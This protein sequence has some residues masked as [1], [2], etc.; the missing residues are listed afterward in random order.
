MPAP[1]LPQL[2]E[3]WGLSWWQ[4]Q[5]ALSRGDAQWIGREPGGHGGGKWSRTRALGTR[6]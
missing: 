4:Q 2:G 1:P 5:F 3:Q 6:A